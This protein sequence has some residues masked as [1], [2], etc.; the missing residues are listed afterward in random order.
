MNTSI[1]PPK[2]VYEALSQTLLLALTASTEKNS[3]RAGK[4]AD[5]FARCCTP[6][7]IK[8]AKATALRKYLKYL[9]T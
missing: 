1:K 9:A 4:L 5:G 3:R 8:R 6:S 2:S 7:Q